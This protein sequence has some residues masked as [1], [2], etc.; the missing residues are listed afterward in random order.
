MVYHKK[1]INLLK[2]KCPVSY[3]YLASF[4]QHKKSP[5][6]VLIHFDNQLRLIKIE[7]NI[8]TYLTFLRFI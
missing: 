3:F 7:R 2:Q 8:S 4:D 6:I 5:N 1:I